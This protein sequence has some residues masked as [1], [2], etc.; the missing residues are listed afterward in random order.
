MS[1]LDPRS[2]QCDKDMRQI[3]DLHSV[4]QNMPD[5]FSDLAKVMRSQILAASM[6][7]WINVPVGCKVIPEG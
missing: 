2:A 4:A 5:A 1:H 6:P 7:V 3:L